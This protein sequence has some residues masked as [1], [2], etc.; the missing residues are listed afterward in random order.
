MPPRKATRG[1]GPAAAP[2]RLLRFPAVTA[3]ENADA[4]L[5]NAVTALER[6]VTRPEREAWRRRSLL[7]VVVA[8]SML[9]GAGAATGMFVVTGLLGPAHRFTVNVYA[10]RDVTA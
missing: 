7:A 2:E 4:P 1:V 3:P 5:E 10:K 6:A 8:F 9:V